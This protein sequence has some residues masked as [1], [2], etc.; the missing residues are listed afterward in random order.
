MRPSTGALGD[1]SP[2][3]IGHDL[4]MPTNR[5]AHHLKV[6]HEAGLI[7]RTRS[8]AAAPTYACNPT[9]PRR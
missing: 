5:V 9:P 3:E 8:T 1:A 6:L 4:S 7:V 2:G